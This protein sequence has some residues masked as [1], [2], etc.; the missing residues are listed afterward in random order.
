M[1]TRIEFHDEGGKTRLVLRQGP[2]TDKMAP[3]ARAGR[4]SSLTKLDTLLGA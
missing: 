3:M 4:E 2:F 1:T